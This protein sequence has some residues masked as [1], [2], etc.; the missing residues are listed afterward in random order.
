[1]K[2]PSMSTLHIQAHVSSDDLFHAIEQLPHAELE[3]FADKVLALR[4]QQNIPVLSQDESELFL[5]I[6]QGVPADLQKRYDVLIA[7]RQDGTLSP[8]DYT[9]LLNLSDTIEQIDARRMEQLALL[10]Q[11]RQVSLAQL[12]QDLGI[13]YPAYE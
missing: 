13:G 10:A 3:Q 4:V 7:Q 2:G 9:E 5:N 11:V 6:N 12:M 1:M 8:E